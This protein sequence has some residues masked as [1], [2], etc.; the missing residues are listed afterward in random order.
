MT[1]TSLSPT[2]QLSPAPPHPPSL[3]DQLRLLARQRGHCEENVAAFAAWARRFI[4]FHAKHHPRDLALPEVAQFL[5]SVAH[6]EI[7]PV[8]ALAVSRDAL[9]FLYREVLHIDLGEL[10][11]P[12]PPR[13]LDQVH[14]V[15]RVRHYAL[16]TEDCYCQ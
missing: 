7:D 2:P 11:L 3:L 6:T 12:R 13:L 8:A 5:D 10:P 4:L 16:S 14:Q 1:A 9:D 15:L